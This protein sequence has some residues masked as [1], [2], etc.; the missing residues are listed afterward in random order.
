[1][2]SE[3]V[4]GLPPFGFTLIL[5]TQQ[6]QV[7][8]VAGALGQ[9]MVYVLND[10]HFDGVRPG[11]RYRDVLFDVERHGFLHGVG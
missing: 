3:N 4:D 1:M 7:L 6:S 11:H 2:F 10:G 5:S 9:V 8:V